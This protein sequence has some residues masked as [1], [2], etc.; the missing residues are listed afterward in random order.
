MKNKPLQAMD[1]Q[2]LISDLLE[3]ECRLH[4]VLRVRIAGLLASFVL[5]VMLGLTVGIYLY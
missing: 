3:L 2:E 5:G 4:D 1:R